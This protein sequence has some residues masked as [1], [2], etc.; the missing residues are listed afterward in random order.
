[1]AVKSDDKKLIKSYLAGDKYAYQEINRFIDISINSFRFKLGSDIEDV[2][3]DIHIKLINLLRNKKFAF[4]SSLFTYVRQIVCHTSIDFIR[5]KEV[6]DNIDI[7]LSDISMSQNNPTPDSILEKKEK[8]THLFRIVGFASDECKE[9]WRLHFLK[10]KKYK[11]IG[12]A[13]GQTEGYVKRKF[14]E[15]REKLKETKELYENNTKPFNA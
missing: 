13:I 7:D 3:S 1:M 10:H 12:E 5:Y 14:Y 8:I 6:R 9:L 11:E 4:E 2:I 15:C